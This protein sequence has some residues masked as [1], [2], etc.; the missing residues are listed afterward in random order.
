M[1]LNYNCPPQVFRLQA[2]Y[3]GK[4]TFAILRGGGGYGKTYVVAKWLETS[5]I[6]KS[7]YIF[8]APTGKAVS[9]AEEKGIFGST[10]H[11]FF[12]ILNN[13]TF[14]SLDRHITMKWGSVEKFKV[15]I[16]K[17][18]YDKKVII[19]DEVSMVN[20]ELLDFIID[21]ILSVVPKMKIIIA[22]DYHQ[23]PAVITD[24]KRMGNPDIDES[25][26]FIMNLIKEGKVDVIDFDT[27]YRS[28]NEEYN[29]WLHNLQ[30]MADESYRCVEA[31]ASKME[32]FFNV[33]EN[34]VPE[35]VESSLTYL[36]YTNAK[37][38]EINDH[39]LSELPTTEPPVWHR[40]K[41]EINEVRYNTI[42]EVRRRDIS[43]Y[44]ILREMQ[45]DEDVPLVV[46]AKILFLTNGENNGEKYRNGDSGIIHE[47]KRNSVIVVK[48]SNAGDY[49]IEIEKHNYE[50]TPYEKSMGLDI[51]VT[52]WPF[53]L[54]YARSIHKAQGDGFTNL[55]LDFSEFLDNKNLTRM[56][57]W[58]LL[59]VCISRVQDP[60]KVWIGRA[61]LD[62]LRLNRKLL[63]TIDFDKLSLN[64][65]HPD[66]AKPIY[67][68]RNVK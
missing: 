46:G 40:A 2:F 45:F 36:C 21:L 34:N 15:D 38:K 60:S 28:D 47:I 26:D 7:E 52:Q 33:H 66:V 6:K 54:S 42:E 13:D 62:K 27:R 17:E 32:Y 19:I 55:H 39:L 9:V 44:Q 59:Y 24:A 63:S 11:S 53:A 57:K 58:R 51:K 68:P 20:N 41:I 49:K 22:G 64:Y 56:D 16:R 8:V 30:N 61:S 14:V 48:Q 10:I 31:L 43:A 3:T 25:I 65:Y 35:E 37:V 12:K 50:S 18:I 5:G 1:L 29:E 4:K 23:L 67:I